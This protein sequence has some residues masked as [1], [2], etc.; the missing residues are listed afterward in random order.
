MTNI[1]KTT[2]F[3]SLYQASNNI[4]AQFDKVM[5]IDGGRLAYFGPA[6]EARGYFEDLGFKEKPRQTTP[7]YLTGVTDPFER[8]Y[9]E[10]FATSAPSDSASLAKAF[11]DSVFLARLSEEMAAYRKELETER[12]IYAEFETAHHEAKRKHTPKVCHREFPWTGPT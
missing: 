9:K 6:N 11:N 10:G 4:Y 8:E 3:V 7:D 12:Q 1:Y 5:V 2:T